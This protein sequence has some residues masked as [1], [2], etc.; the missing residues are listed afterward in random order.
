MSKNLRELQARRAK[1]VAAMRAITDLAAKE[2]RDLTEAE[3]TEFGTHRATLE[4]NAKSIEREELLIA[5]ERAAGVVTVGNGQGH[6]EAHVRLEDDPRRGFSGL[7]EFLR[8]ARSEGMNFGSPNDERLRIGASQTTFANE[9]TGADGGF[10]VPPQFASEIWTFSLDEDALLPYT[11]NLPVA[12]NGMVLPKDETTPWGTDGIRAYWQGEGTA[13]TPTKPKLGAMGLRLHKLMALVPVT[14]ELIADQNALGSYLPKKVGSSVRWKTSDAILNG[15]GAGQPLGALSGAAALT[16]AKDGSQ[17]T[18][19]LSDTNIANMVAR[20]PP[21][22]L[23]R[24][25]WLVNN[26]VLGSLYTLKNSAGYPVFAPF[27]GG[28]GAITGP[29]AGRMFGRPVIISQHANTFSSLGD[30]TLLDLSYYQTI[31]KSSGVQVDTSMHI[32]FDQD[33]TAYRTIFRL[34]GQP[35]I[36]AQISPNKGSNKMSPF[37]QLQAR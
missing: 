14:D 30:V 16:V 35:K 24:A 33:L 27:G 9:G 6:V 25:I 29:A 26:D 36:S 17:Q 28:E 22:S 18:G 5:A 2:N 19:T 32:Y 20:L 13:G 1:T 21:G 10:L 4:A 8:V 23:M 12:G 31:S 3:D 11:D 7:G 37:L 15:T 34:D